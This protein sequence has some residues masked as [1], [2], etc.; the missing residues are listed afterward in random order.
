M[1]LRIVIFLSVSLLLVAGALFAPAVSLGVKFD[2]VSGSYLV[3]PADL[4]LVCPGP[5]F[6]S[7]GE[8]GTTVGEFK[9]LG[10]A[11]ASITAQGTS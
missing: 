8:S 7:G 2:S 5:V 1:I 4:N 10:S 11:N 9:R 3:K 6:R